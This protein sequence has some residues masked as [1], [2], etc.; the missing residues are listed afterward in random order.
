M[1]S[2]SDVEDWLQDAGY[3][4]YCFI[5]W[6][7]T[8][9]Q[10][11][12][13]CANFLKES[14]EENLADTIDKPK[15]FLDQ[16]HIKGGDDWQKII[17]QALCRS[18]VLVAVCAPVY[19]KPS[20]K[21]CG[22]E[23]AGMQNLGEK[24]LPKEDFHTIIPIM[25]R[26]ND[27]LPDPVSKIQYFDFSRVLTLGVKFF[28]TSEYRVMVEGIRRRIEQVAIAL[29]NNESL[30]DCEEFS[31]PSESAFTKYNVKKQHPPL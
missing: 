6:P 13:D 23:W 24:R 15:V 17:I 7:H 18:V 10:A 26:K 21:W 9:N 29:K 4:Y 14:L 3:E 8:K 5:S 28:D 11:I 25:V 19:Y 12:T 16:S 30:A 20:H 2:L 1:L 27:P 31:L 22:L